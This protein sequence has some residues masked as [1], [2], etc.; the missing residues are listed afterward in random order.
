MIENNSAVQNMIPGQPQPKQ[1]LTISKEEVAFWLNQIQSGI[2]RKKE[3]FDDVMEYDTLV[4][5][6]ECFQNKIGTKIETIAILDE[7]ATALVSVISGTYYQNPSVTVKAKRPEAD[8]MIQPS[9]MYLL[10][11]PDFK[12]F[13]QSDLMK[14]AIDY[15]VK[16]FGLKLEAQQAL[17]DLLVAGFCIIEC[18]HRSVQPEYAQTDLVDQTPLEAITDGVKAVGQ[19]M[20]DMFSNKEGALSTDDV[21]AKVATETSDHSDMFQDQTY[22][23]RWSPNEI[24]FDPD[25]R[26]FKESRFVCKIVKMTLANFKI[27]YPKFK[28]RI[29]AEFVT[30]TDSGLK[31][32]DENKKQVTVY[33][34]EIKQKDGSVNVLCCTK[35]INEDLDYYKRSVTTNDFTLKY[36]SIDKYG[37]IY[38][39]SRAKKAKKPQ[40][41]LNHYSTIQFEHADRSPRKIA[42]FMAGLSEAGKATQTNGDVYGLVEKIIPGP[43]YE[44][45]PQPT[46]SA[47]NEKL[48]MAMRESVNK[49]IGTSEIAKAGGQSDNK[50][51]GQD[52]LENQAFQASTSQV[53]DSLADVLREVLDCLKDIIMQFWDGQD[54]FNVTGLP[55][56][57]AWYDPS[58]GPLADLLL[59]DFDL[60]LDITSAQRENPVREREDN[61]KLL[62][63]LMNPATQMFIQSKGKTLNLNPIKNV[64]KSFGHNPDTIFEDA[65]QPMMPQAMS[66]MP[67]A[68]PQREPIPVP[69]HQGVPAGAL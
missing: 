45:M 67:G 22:F 61:I 66:G 10:Q 41:D 28:D 2:K 57:D 13:S 56:G 23:K 20:V 39:V 33:E 44:A 9:M 68:P 21:E 5:Y 51:L 47:D 30:S 59:G 3:E 18:N 35:G 1:P 69:L 36:G 14:G 46:V 49:H 42:T 19:K 64:I 4:R 60:D 38:P 24:I 32:K 52:Q 25:A 55:G 15:A 63:L 48:Q 7:M 12:S 34:L 8:Q 29:P 27:Q 58:M 40:D 17:F 50:L 31:R 43:V 65:P 6:F 54:Y 11:H 16:K 62:E 26:T 37:K 53:Q